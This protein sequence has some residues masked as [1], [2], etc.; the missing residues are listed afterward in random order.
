MTGRVQADDMPNCVGEICATSRRP[1]MVPID[2]GVD[3]AGRIG[4]KIREAYVVVADDLPWT[5]IAA[6]ARQSVP[7]AGRKLSAAS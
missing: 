7:A 1:G 4:D 6:T 5:Q 2:Q 3:A